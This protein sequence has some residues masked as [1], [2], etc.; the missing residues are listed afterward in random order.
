LYYSRPDE[1]A[2]IRSG[3]IFPATLI[4]SAALYALCMALF[5]NFYPLF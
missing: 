2:G 4:V 1:L 5:T 3:A